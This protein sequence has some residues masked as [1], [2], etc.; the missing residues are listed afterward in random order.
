MK[1]KRRLTEM[2]GEGDRLVPHRDDDPYRVRYERLRQ[3]VAEHLTGRW[4]GAEVDKRMDPEIHAKLIRHEE[5]L[6]AELREIDRP[7]TAVAVGAGGRS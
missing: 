4:A 3:A 6:A 7:I 1:G 2:L 5:R